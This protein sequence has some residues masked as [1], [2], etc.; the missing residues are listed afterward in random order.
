MFPDHELY[1][2]N[3]SGVGFWNASPVKTD[4]IVNVKWLTRGVGFRN[5]GPLKTD[6]TTLQH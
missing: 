4:A 2:V 5:G 6:T 3:K 1:S